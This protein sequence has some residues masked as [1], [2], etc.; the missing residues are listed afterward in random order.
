MAAASDSVEIRCPEV[1][2]PTVTVSWARERLVSFSRGESNS[3]MLCWLTV[4]V[5][6]NYDHA[7]H[8]RVRWITPTRK[9][10]ACTLNITLTLTVMVKCL[11]GGDYL[12]AGSR[13][14]ENVDRSLG[15]GQWLSFEPCCQWALLGVQINRL[16]TIQHALP[17]L[18]NLLYIHKY[19]YPTASLKQI[20]SAFSS[21]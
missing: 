19:I 5:C 13:R 17:H 11:T 20:N 10:P 18:L 21:S 6:M 7:N 9:D 2:T 4:P 3:K 8:V 14:T 1:R 12:N 16:V 15:V